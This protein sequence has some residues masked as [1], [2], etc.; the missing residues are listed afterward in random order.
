MRLATTKLQFEMGTLGDLKELRGELNSVKQRASSSSVSSL[1]PFSLSGFPVFDGRYFSDEG[2]LWLERNEASRIE[3]L[4]SLQTEIQQ[5]A[6]LFAIE[7][8]DPLN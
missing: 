2:E 3:A 5:R 1:T 6:S 4:R 8:L 7:R